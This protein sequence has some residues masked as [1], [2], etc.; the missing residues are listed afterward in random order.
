MKKRVLITGASEGL[1]RSF[2]LQFA[3]QGYQVTG[4]ARNRERLESLVDELQAIHAVPHDYLAA[5][6]SSDEGQRACVEL[7]QT[8]DFQVLVNNAGFSRFG[9]FRDACI[10]DELALMDVNMRSILRLAHAYLQRARAGDAMINLSSITYYLPTPIQAS[11]VASKCWIA[12]LSESLWYQ[13]RKRGV[14]VQGL[15]PGMTKTQFMERAS[16]DIRQ[17]A[18]LDFVSSSPDRVVRASYRAMLK[19]KGPILVPGLF[20]KLTVL[21][22]K[23][24]PRKWSVLLLGKVGDLS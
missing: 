14:Y 2:A 20:N 5:D 17:R 22:M 24:L 1:G 9:D 12:S 11:Y 6:L 16:G 19:R 18:L 15:C 4:V 10:A 23:L 8:H 3:Q 7:I 13:A 21:C